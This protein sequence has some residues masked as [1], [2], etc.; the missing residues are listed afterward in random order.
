MLGRRVRGRRNDGLAGTAVFPGITTI[1]CDGIVPIPGDGDLTEDGDVPLRRLLELSPS[2]R[3]S[4]VV[5]NTGST[6]EQARDSRSVQAL[7][8]PRPGRGTIAEPD[9]SIKGAPQFQGLVCLPGA[10]PHNRVTPTCGERPRLTDDTS[11][12]TDARRSRES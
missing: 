3:N 1:S 9:R 11:Q 6:R 12:V 8:S 7:E 10:S 2:M 5:Q 4:S